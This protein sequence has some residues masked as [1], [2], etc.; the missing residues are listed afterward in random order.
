MLKLITKMGP[1]RIT[2]ISMILVLLAAAIGMVLLKGCTRKVDSLETVRIGAATQP[3]AGLVY[4]ADEKGFFKTHGVNATIKNYE[5]GVLAANALLADTVDV[6]TAT[7]FVMALKSF[8]SQN[9]MAFSQ[10]ANTNA[11]ELVARKDL[12]IR[13]ISDLKGKRIGLPR[14][15]IS[16][17]FLGTYLRHNNIPLSSVKLIDLAPLAAEEAL[18]KGSVDAVVIWEP[19]VTEIKKRLGDTAVIWPVQG[20]NDYYFLLIAK[21]E[22]LR[23]SPA[24]AEKMLRALVDAEEFAGKHPEE[25]ERIIE[26][27]I[28]YRPGEVRLR[29]SRGTLKVRLDQALLTLMEAEA[30]WIIQN[31]LTPKRKMPNYF[32]MIYLKALEGVKPEAVGIIR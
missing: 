13:K 11:T 5:A 6:A 7:E 15:S 20:R 3:V 23:R 1:K 18:C 14:G 17:F 19:H 12:G 21:E 32:N 28:N 16:D 24:T 9:L 4:V 29:L 26:S 2:F 25:A 8:D 30:H 27:R 31:N 10:I 22:F